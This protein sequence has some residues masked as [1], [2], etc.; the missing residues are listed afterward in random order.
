MKLPKQLSSFLRLLFRFSADTWQFCHSWFHTY[1][2]LCWNTSNKVNWAMRFI[3][4]LP[5]NRDAS[6]RWI[7]TGYSRRWHLYS[8]DFRRKSCH[9]C[10]CTTYDG[11]F[12]GVSALSKCE[13]KIGLLVWGTAACHS[14]TWQEMIPM[15]IKRH[16]PCK[17]IKDKR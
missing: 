4:N 14:K 10:G 15:W 1:C 12:P 13:W 6:C 16:C 3:S 8:I 9:F 2:P 17:G 11:L 7:L 5:Q